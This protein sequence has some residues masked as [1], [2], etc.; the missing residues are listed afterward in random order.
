MFSAPF[1]E[2]KLQNFAKYFVGSYTLIM[3][4]FALSLSNDV[5]YQN[6]KGVGG[7]GVKGQKIFSLVLTQL[8][9]WIMEIEG[10]FTELKKLAEVPRYEPT[11]SR[12][13]G[14]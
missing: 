6:V 13:L 7:G 1:R 5:K 9:I 3:I 11:K 10:L 14:V 12:V 8:K 2:R 4:S